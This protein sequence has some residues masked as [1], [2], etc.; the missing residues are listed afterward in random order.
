MSLLNEY[1]SQMQ[2]TA[3]TA[4]LIDLKALQA[5]HL[6]K[7]FERFVSRELDIGPKEAHLLVLLSMYCPTAH[8][9]DRLLFEFRSTS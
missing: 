3:L 8:P 2:S 4:R 6:L 1:Q 9:V 5:G 7:P